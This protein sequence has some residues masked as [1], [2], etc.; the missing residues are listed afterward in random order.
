MM[1]LFAVS[2]ACTTLLC[3]SDWPRSAAIGAGCLRRFRPATDNFE[4]PQLVWSQKSDGYSS[5]IIIG[6]AFS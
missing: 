6:I 4:G 2:L 1:R 5:P 3:A